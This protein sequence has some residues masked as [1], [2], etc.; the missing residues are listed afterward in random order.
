MSFEYRDLRP[1][2]YQLTE[3]FRLKIDLARFPT[4]IA[5]PNEY[6]CFM[7]H[8][9]VIS[10]GYAW[11]GPSGPAIDTKTF[12]RGSLVHDALYQLLRLEAVKLSDLH[13]ARKYADELLVELCRQDG[14]NRFRAWYVYW[15]VR[16]FGWQFSQR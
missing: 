3:E 1:Y 4:T 9:L 7:G 13:E 11:D 5:V 10:S 14:M 16:Y 6:L 12:M 15:V 2:K 8:D